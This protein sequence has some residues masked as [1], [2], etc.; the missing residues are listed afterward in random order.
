MMEID[1]IL[2][3]IQQAKPLIVGWFPNPSVRVTRST[4]Q[5]HTTS[6]AWEAISFSVAT[7]DSVPDGLSVHW[8]AGTPTRLTCR[9]AGVYHLVASLEFAASAT[10]QRGVTIRLNGTTYQ[11]V[12]QVDA[13]AA[14]VTSLTVSAAIKLAVGDYVEMLGF[15]NSGGALNMDVLSGAPSLAMTLAARIP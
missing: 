11:N 1:R 5:A 15:Q 6:G 8:A 3:M 13:A 12:H 4:A 7:W 10:G 14:N 9:V 2:K